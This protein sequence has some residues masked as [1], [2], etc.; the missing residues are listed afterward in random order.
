MLEQRRQEQREGAQVAW[1]G[2]Q[3]DAEREQ[4]EKLAHGDV[5]MEARL[6]QA[7]QR[8]ISAWRAAEKQRY[9]AMLAERR[10]DTLVVPFQVQDHAFARDIRSLMTA[11]LALAMAASPG[12][13]VSIA[14]PHVVTRAFGDGERRYTSPKS[15][16]SPMLSR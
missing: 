4:R 6:P 3:A 10:F 12:A 16:G 5:N 2:R 1:M 9:E 15:C 7:Y 13:K 8:P 14:D 11:Q